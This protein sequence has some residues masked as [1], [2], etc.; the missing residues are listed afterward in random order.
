MSPICYHYTNSQFIFNKTLRLHVSALGL[1]SDYLFPSYP[2]AFDLYPN[3]AGYLS[4]P[5]FKLL[6]FWT[7]LY[8]LTS[9]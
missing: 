6:F 8:L 4:E 5:L 2:Q 9:T 1:L 7:T 3:N